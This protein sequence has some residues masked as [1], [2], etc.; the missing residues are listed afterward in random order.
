[1]QLPSAMCFH[2][3]AHETNAWGGKAP[4]CAVSLE[5]KMKTT[6]NLASLAG[7]SLA[8]PP[9]DPRD[10]KIPKPRLRAESS[11]KWGLPTQIWNPCS[12]LRYRPKVEL[13][14]YLDVISGKY[15]GIIGMYCNLRRVC[16]SM[17]YWQPLPPL[18]YL[19]VPC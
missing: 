18:R 15:M 14:C 10:V 12:R 6:R 13:T 11:L 2:Y 7:G 16:G 1:M 4:G 5:N 9:R 17:V 3:A 8:G 19:Q